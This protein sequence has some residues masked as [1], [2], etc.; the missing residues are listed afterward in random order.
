MTTTQIIELVV[1]A[2]LI[3]LSV[4]VYRR[5]GPEG[6]GRYGNQGSV[7]VLVIAL[8]LAVHGLGLLNYRPSQ[9][10]IDRL[11]AQGAQ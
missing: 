3:I 4:V 2:G 7:I 10:E 8:I 5:R 11:T 9:G 1:A 6:E